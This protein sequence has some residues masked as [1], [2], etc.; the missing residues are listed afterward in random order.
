MSSCCEFR[1]A[2]DVAAACRDL[3]GIADPRPAARGLGAGEE[4]SAIGVTAGYVIGGV[5]RLSLAA[6]SLSF[7]LPRLLI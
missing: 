1:D 2:D 6:L 4:A 3:A 7:T 5:F